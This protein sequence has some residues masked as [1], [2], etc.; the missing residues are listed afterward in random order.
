M[1]QQAGPR[2]QLTEGPRVN[3]F[4]AGV[5]DGVVLK[6]IVV[7]AARDSRFEAAMLDWLARRRG[8]I[9]SN[10]ESIPSYCVVRG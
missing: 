4:E 7:A 2:G 9:I 6:Q 1:A 10:R 8:E 5:L 3:G